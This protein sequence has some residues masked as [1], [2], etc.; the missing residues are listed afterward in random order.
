[1]TKKSASARRAEKTATAVAKQKQ[2]EGKQAT[3][4]QAKAA[5]EA[6]AEAKRVTAKAELEEIG[7]QIAAGVKIMRDY[8]TSAEEKAGYDLRKAQDELDTINKVLLVQARGKCRE[9]GE[10]FEKFRQQYCPDLGR[11]YVVL[12]I[13]HGRKTVEQDPAEKRESVAKTRARASSTSAVGDGSTVPKVPTPNGTTLDTS[14]FSQKTLDQIARVTGNGVDTEAPAE[15]RKAAASEPKPCDTGD[16]AS[17]L[18]DVTVSRITP[19]TINQNLDAYGRRAVGRRSVRLQEGL[20]P[21]SP[22]HDRGRGSQK[23]PRLLH[24]RLRQARQESLHGGG[25]S[26]EHTPTTTVRDRT[27]WLADH[28]GGTAVQARRQCSAWLRR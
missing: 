1:M 28:P 26:V 18:D 20:R 13:A 27:V 16:D 19:G 5:R 2:A 10:S 25:M 12:A 21:I 22:G 7:P 6:E 3:R 24:D 23:G 4:A 14:G 17:A 11:L 9:A 8:D 15:M